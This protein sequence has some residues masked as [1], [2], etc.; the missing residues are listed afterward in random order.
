MC[1]LILIAGTWLNP[2]LVEVLRPNGPACYVTI[3]QEG[4]VL[5]EPRIPLRCEEFAAQI[6]AAREGENE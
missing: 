2:C 6:N 4:R 3:A 1:S 5:K